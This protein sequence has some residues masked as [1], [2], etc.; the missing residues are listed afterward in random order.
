MSMRTPIWRLIGLTGSQYGELQ[1]S[2]GRL[3][4]SPASGVGFDVE[5]TEVKDINFPWHYFSGGFKMTLAGEEFRFSFIEPHN[6][7]ADVRT[8][9]EVGKQWKKTLVAG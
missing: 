5:L 6:D 8:G 2:N 1:I 3:K 9:R 7:Y 4:Y